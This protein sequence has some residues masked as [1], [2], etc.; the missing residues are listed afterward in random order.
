MTTIENPAVRWMDGDFQV[1]P[2]GGFQS[3]PTAGRAEIFVPASSFATY[4][5]SGA[6]VVTNGLHGWSLDADAVEAVQAS[7]V[8]PD[9]WAQFNATVW[10]S[11]VSTGA[12]AVVWGV[13]HESLAEGAVPGAGASTEVTGTASTTAGLLVATAVTVQGALTANAITRFRVSRE[14]DDAADTVDNDA[15]FHGLYLA[16]VLV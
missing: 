5:G 16:R 11:N 3:V 6:Q 12:G 4:S 1:N 15:V 13:N 10:W 9:N 14:A 8:L 7:V 2:G